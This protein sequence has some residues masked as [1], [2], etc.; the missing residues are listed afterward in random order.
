MSTEMAEIARSI[1]AES[2]FS[3]G[4][5]WDPQHLQSAQY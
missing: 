3:S 1:R 4:K 2:S 5:Q